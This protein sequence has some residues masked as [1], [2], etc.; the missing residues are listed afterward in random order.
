MNW[1]TVRRHNAIRSQKADK[2]KAAETARKQEIINAGGALTLAE[3]KAGAATR[4][5]DPPASGFCRPREVWTMRGKEWRMGFG[6]A[7]FH[8][9]ASYR[10]DCLPHGSLPVTAAARKWLEQQ[11]PE[12]EWDGD[13]ATLS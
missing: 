7:S 13:F 8:V 6:G 9:H 2:R 12:K 1:K 3:V 11:F 4:R 10:Q 5:I